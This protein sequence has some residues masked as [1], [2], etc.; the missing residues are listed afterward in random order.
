AMFDEQVKNR[1]DLAPLPR[2]QPRRPDHNRATSDRLNVGLNPTLPG[3][4]RLKLLLI[5]PRQYALPLEMVF[6]GSDFTLVFSVV[7]EKDI[8]GLR[9]AF[10][11]EPKL[12]R[13]GFNR[14]FQLLCVF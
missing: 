11:I 5:E 8:E 4:S 1:V 3:R 12:S 7:A 2:A 13:E 6:N 10:P 14:S 9:Q